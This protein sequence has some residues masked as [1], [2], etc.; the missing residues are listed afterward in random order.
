MRTILVIDDKE[1]IRKVLKVILE[2]EGYR[3]L[4]ADGGEEG[5]QLAADFLPDLIISDIRMDDLGGKE[6][7]HLLKSRGISIPFIFM[8]AFASIE[9]AVSAI[10]E[11]A[12]DYLT[13]PVDYEYLKKTIARMI[14]TPK[15]EN[16]RKKK[17]IGSSPVMRKLLERIKTVASSSSTVLITGESGTGKE[18]IAR[19]IHEESERNQNGFIPINCSALSESLLESELFGY[20][21]GAFTG[22]VVQKQGFFETAHR[23]TLFLDEVSELSPSTQV[24]L[25][26]VLQEHTFT[27]VGGTDFVDVDVRI[28]AAT[29]KNLEEL[30][31]TGV[32][33][34]DLYYRLNVIPINTPSLREHLEDLEI[35]IDAIIKRICLFENISVPVVEEN[36]IR[37]LKTYSWPGNIRELENLIERLLILNHPE[38]LEETLL[39]EE[40]TIFG[41]ASGSVES[42]RDRIISALRL[43]G[44]NK[45]ETSKILAM[46]RRT[47]YHKINKYSILPEEYKSM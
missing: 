47:L 10:K 1:N 31:K 37:T 46:P 39:F 19:A 13:K 9:D 5:L 43:C 28:I 42:E 16:S 17:L 18:L 12:V 14:R 29:N 24:K 2:K 44:G 15:L 41:A 40:T 27:R 4:T 22:A 8:T 3:V 34:H 21:K 23:G 35:L 11:G 20:E 30:V 6:L 26:R 45:T 32:F 7:F 33:R 38:R 25:L 36:F